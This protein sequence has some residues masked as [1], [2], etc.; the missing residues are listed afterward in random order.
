MPDVLLTDLKIQLTIAKCIIERAFVGTNKNK[1]SLA[2]FDRE[3]KIK[4]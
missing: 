2:S 1:V 3:R 4:P